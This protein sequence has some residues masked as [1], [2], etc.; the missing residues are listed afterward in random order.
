MN[1][2]IF[3]NIHNKRFHLAEAAPICNGRWRGEFGYSAISQTAQSILNGTYSFP[4]DFDEA[5]RELC[6]EFA[7]IRL[8][9]PKDSL[10][11]TITEEEWA[12]HWNKARE[13]T[14]SSYSGRHFGYYKAARHSKHILQFQALLATVLFNKGVV[15]SRWACGLSV[16]L[17]KL[18]GCSLVSKLFPPRRTS[19]KHA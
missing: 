10:R 5:T 15:L 2:A 7:R 17:Q 1:T 14:S 18:F 8:K 16:M 13:D 4:D 19:P 6:E 11:M 3:E 9:I 12:S